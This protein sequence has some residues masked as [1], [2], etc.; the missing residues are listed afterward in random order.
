MFA[1]IVTIFSCVEKTPLDASFVEY[2][3]VYPQFL[4]K[5]QTLIGC[6]LKRTVTV[7]FKIQTV[8]KRSYLIFEIGGTFRSHIFL[9]KLAFSSI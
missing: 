4:M 6:K 9:K 5:E 3:F 1:E 2:T 7:T 8:L